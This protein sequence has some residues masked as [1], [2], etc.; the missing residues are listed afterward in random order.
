MITGKED[1][2]QSLMEAFLMEKGTREFY[3]HAADK[4][5]TPDAG[6][7]FRKLSS[8]EE[9]H[10]DY[11]Q[12]LYLAVQGERDFKGFE[13][14]RDSAEAPYTEAGIPVKDME[15]KLD[16]YTHLDDKGALAFALE[17]EGK[18]YNL[19]RKMSE[20]ARDNNAR[21]VFRDMMDQ[22]LKHVDYLKKLRG[23]LA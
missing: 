19:Y 2:L 4:A 14:F 10:M 18:S 9:R 11:I 1:L 22:E 21:V 15:A 17:L 3:T 6:E 8:W 12:Y 7:T 5:Q 16:S 13:E 20:N 23:K